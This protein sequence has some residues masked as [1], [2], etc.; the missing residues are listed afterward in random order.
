MKKVLQDKGDVLLGEVGGRLEAEVE[1]PIAGTVRR[2][3]LELHEQR[4][5]EVE[6]DADARE[7]AKQRNHP[8]VVLQG[9][10]PH[11]GENVLPGDEVLVIRLVHVPQEGHLGHR[12]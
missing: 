10:Q 12:C 5:D 3:G 1:I 6:R 7:L 4:G 2:E 11:P 8:V 9:M